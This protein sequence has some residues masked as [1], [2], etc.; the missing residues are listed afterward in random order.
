[1]MSY[2]ISW[3][4][5]ESFLTLIQSLIMVFF[6]LVSFRGSFLI[7]Y[8]VTFATAMSATAMAI[9]LGVLS[10][11]NAR[12]AQ[13]LLPVIF[14][15]RLLF[16][17]YFVSSDL[18]PKLLRWSQYVCVL[19]YAVRLLML[20]DKC[21]SGS[22]W[23]RDIL[24]SDGRVL[25]FLSFAGFISLAKVG[26]EILLTPLQDSRKSFLQKDWLLIIISSP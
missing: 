18:V 2:F 22:G 9:L 13:Q 7:Y 11:G 12:I 3:L 15:P 26:N 1:V 8:V 4:C 6:I 21:E 24:G 16:S 20:E 14:I 23:H 19:T 10:G 25:C 5:V 17:G